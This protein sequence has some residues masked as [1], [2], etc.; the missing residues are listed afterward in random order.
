MP[1]LFPLVEPDE[2]KCSCMKCSCE[3]IDVVVT[4]A[5]PGSVRIE[6]SGGAEV[7]AYGVKVGFSEG[8]LLK[9]VVQRMQCT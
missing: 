2:V 5:E 1:W 9:D 4:K 8:P 7:V 3:H 6:P